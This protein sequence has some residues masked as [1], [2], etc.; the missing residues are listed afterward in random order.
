PSGRELERGSLGGGAEVVAFS[1]ASGRFAA[2]GME[3]AVFVSE[4]RRADRPAYFELPADVR[5]VAFSPDGRRF[6]VATR[7][8]HW[9]SLVRIADIDGKVLHDFE[10]QGAPVIDKLFFLDPNDVLA[11]WSNKLFLIA[12]D[13]SSVTPLPVAFAEMRIDPSGKA[14][15]V[16]DDGVSRMY[17][18]PGLRQTTSLNGPPGTLLR[19]A[20]EG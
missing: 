16:Q 5:S 20:E 6:A 17:S 1:T 8:A 7:S 15:A 10:F 2:G 11:Q 14:L 19:T 18:L 13:S 9:L 12:I 3:G 4:T